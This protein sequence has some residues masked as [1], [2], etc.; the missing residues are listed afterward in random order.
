[1]ESGWQFN[2]QEVMEIKFVDSSS[3]LESVYRFRYRVYVDEMNRAQ[4]YADHDA[5]VI[6][7]PLDSFGH[8][9]IALDKGRLV[10]TLR[11]NFLREGDIGE[12]N[13]F[14]G[15]E[16]LTERER[17]VTSITTRLMIE[18]EYR[19]GTLAVR[20]S[21]A[22]FAFALRHQIETDFIDCNPPL[23]A[24]FSKMGHKKVRCITH[25]EYG[26]V[27]VMKLN[28]L[29]QNYLRSIRSPFVR[30]RPQLNVNT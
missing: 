12:Y 13:S 27:T 3:H 24:F 5:R 6:I 15:L 16:E 19:S 10:G 29:D 30:L 23:D 9:L 18:K 2:K 14:Y 26:D 7:D 25:P 21:K 20:L 28:L 17:A 8:I 22:V 11:I 1:M 4:R